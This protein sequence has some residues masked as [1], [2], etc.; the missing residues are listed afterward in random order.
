MAH[1]LKDATIRR[2]TMRLM[3]LHLERN[4]EISLRL[5]FMKFKHSH[6]IMKQ[7]MHHRKS[8][9]LTST[10]PISPSKARSNN[11]TETKVTP[12]KRIDLSK[13]PDVTP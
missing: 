3:L 2:K 11:L 5:A 8:S 13:K 4:R 7:K 10:L 6:L 12:T 1:D 9:S